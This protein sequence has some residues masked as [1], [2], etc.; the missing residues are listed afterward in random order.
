MRRS[1]VS[2]ASPKEPKRA[3]GRENP[4]LTIVVAG[5]D[6]GRFFPDLVLVVMAQLFS[7]INQYQV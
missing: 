5:G 1:D 3:Q 2:V 7:S 4:V 6:N